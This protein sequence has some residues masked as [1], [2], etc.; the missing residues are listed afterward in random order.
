MKKAVAIAAGLLVSAIGVM[1]CLCTL[2]FLSLPN[3]SRI[4][5]CL[6]TEFKKV[7]LCNRDA[8]YVVL[9]QVAPIA[10][11]AIIISEDGSFYSHN[12]FDWYEMRQSAE[13]NLASQGFRRGGSTITQQLAKN[14]FLNGEKSLFRKIKEAYLTWRLEKIL[15]KDQILEKYL[16]VVELGPGIFGIKAAAQ[17]Y[18]GKAPGEL[19]AAEGAFLAMMLPNP[20]KYYASFR[21][22]KLTDF[23]RGRILDICKKLSITG[24]ISSSE[25]EMVASS[26]DGF[27]WLGNVNEPVSASDPAFSEPSDDEDSD[28]QTDIQ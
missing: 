7:H 22:K 6:T 16:N 3:P 2:L 28:T 9:G 4:K 26:L 15:S 25:Y 11:A 1:A 5:G 21:Q 13:K 8:N 24:R 10:R 18:F 23:A 17:H 19:N 20:I 27:P 14:V 12:G